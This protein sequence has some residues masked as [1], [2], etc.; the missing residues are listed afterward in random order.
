MI[1]KGRG[2]LHI[3]GPDQA[4][5]S[6]SVIHELGSPAQDRR[7]GKVISINGQDVAAL[8]APDPT[9]ARPSTGIPHLNLTHPS[10]AAAC[11]R[12]AATASKPASKPVSLNS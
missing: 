7:P 12:H 10:L 2:Y 6:H 1:T 3:G 8:P 4:N 11:A 5:R 9:I